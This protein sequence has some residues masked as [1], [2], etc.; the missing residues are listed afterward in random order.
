MMT[1]ELHH[2]L[3]ELD[4]IVHQED[5]WLFAMAIHQRACYRTVA[6][7]GVI[8]HGRGRNLEPSGSRL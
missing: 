8:S 3:A 5:G 2:H 7:G 6:T 1:E 4:V